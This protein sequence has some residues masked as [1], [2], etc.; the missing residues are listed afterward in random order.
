MSSRQKD[1]L[2]SFANFTWMH[3]QLA[4]NT[5]QETPWKPFEL[6]QA[7]HRKAFSIIRDKVFVPAN[8]A[9]DSHLKSF[10]KT[11]IVSSIKHKQ[12]LDREVVEQLFTAK[13][14]GNDTPE[15]LLQTAWFY[16][17]L[18]F[19]RRGWEDQRN[20]GTRKNSERPEI[21]CPSRASNEKS[22]WRASVTT[23]IIRKP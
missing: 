20:M 18:Y 11:G 15:S 6:T 8:K 7:P 23:K 13:Q 14:L 21:H 3:A 17:M 2:K 12:A 16:L 22:S 10:A 1:S 19:G 9:L 4:D 5:I